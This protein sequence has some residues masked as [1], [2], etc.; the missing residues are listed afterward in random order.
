MLE[1]G[2]PAPWEERG[3]S[4][5]PSAR[6]DRAK[7]NPRPHLSLGQKSCSAVTRDVQHC[8]VDDGRGWLPQGSSLSATFLGEVSGNNDRR[9]LWSKNQE[10]QCLNG[11][12]KERVTLRFTSWPLMGP[13]TNDNNVGI[14]RQGCRPGC[15]GMGSPGHQAARN[16]GR[17]Q[18]R[19]ETDILKQKSGIIPKESVSG[20]IRGRP[21][22]KRN[23]RA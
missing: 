21:S 4:V 13:K 14:P 11:T 6:C 22:R 2:R 12:M 5:L 16:R 10:T 19:Q 9:D 8:R 7:Q 20:R 17:G 18:P 1:H 15:V 3:A 23:W